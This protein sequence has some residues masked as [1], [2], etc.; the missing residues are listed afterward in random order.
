V[1][2]S[3][4]SLGIFEMTNG[5]KLFVGPFSLMDAPDSLLILIQETGRT[6]L[7]L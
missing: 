4:H 1:G 3:I 2:D 5:K 6:E 7:L